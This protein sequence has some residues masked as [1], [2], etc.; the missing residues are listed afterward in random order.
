MDPYVIERLLFE[1]RGRS[2]GLRDVTHENPP[3]SNALSV[4]NVDIDRAAPS[5]TRC[6]FTHTNTTLNGQINPYDAQFSAD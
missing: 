1:H 5:I 4:S 3:S 2:R 6:R